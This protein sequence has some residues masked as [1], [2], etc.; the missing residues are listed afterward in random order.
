MTEQAGVNEVRLSDLPLQMLPTG[1]QWTRR[2]TRDEWRAAQYLFQGTK[3]AH[4]WNVGDWWNDGI[5][6][7]GEDDAIQM[8][9]E[10]S[11]GTVTNYGS[12]C[13]KFTTPTLR[14]Y[15]THISYYQELQRL[16]IARAEKVLQAVV[17][18]REPGHSRLERADVKLLVKAQSR[19]DCPECHSR[20]H[21]M[22]AMPEDA[23]TLWVCQNPECEHEMPYAVQADPRRHACVLTVAADGS[24]SVGDPVPTWAWNNSYEIVIRERIAA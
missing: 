16:P 21:I 8:L 24:V 11:P 15:T 17:T 18:S 14:G 20:K 9:D 12:L 10:Y 23:P 13:N 2:P 22:L 4:A 1:L 5:R 6:F 3:A 7:F 19:R